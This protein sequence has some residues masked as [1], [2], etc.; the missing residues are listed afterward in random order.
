VAARVIAQGM[1]PVAGGLVLGLVASLGATRFLGAL[2]YGVEPLDPVTLAGVVVVL[3][4][5]AAAACVVPAWYASRVDPMVSIR[6][7]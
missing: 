7:E 3:G 2:L 4:G 1:L 6:A 5:A